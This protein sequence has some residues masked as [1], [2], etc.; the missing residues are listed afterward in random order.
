MKKLLFLL[1]LLPFISHAQPDYKKDIYI[2]DKRCFDYDMGYYYMKKVGNRIFGVTQSF[3]SGDAKLIIMNLNF[4]TIKTVNYGG[5]STIDEL[6]TI[7]ELSNDN[8]LLSGRSASDDGDVNGP[9]NRAAQMWFLEVDTNGIIKKSKTIGGTQGSACLNVTIAKDGF[10]YCIGATNANDYDFQRSLWYGPFASDIVIF[11]LDTAYNIVWNKIFTTAKEEGGGAIVEG[12]NNTFIFSWSCEDTATSVLGSQAKGYWDVFTIQVDSAGNELRKY[13]WGGNQ[14]D[15]NI[16]LYYDSINYRYYYIGFSHS[17]NTDATYRTGQSGIMNLWIRIT[18][19]NFNMLYSKCYGSDKW[20]N[21]GFINL[22]STF[23]QGNLW[24]SLQP[25]V[26]KGDFLTNDNPNDSTDNLVIGIIDTSANLIGKMGIKS[27]VTIQVDKLLEINNELYAVGVTGGTSGTIINNFG[28]GSDTTDWKYFV[29]K[30]GEAPLS[31]KE[32]TK[33]TQANLF[34]FFPNPTSVELNIKWNE[35]YIG[36]NYHLAIYSQEGKKLNS[37]NGVCE[38]SNV[39]MP[40]SNFANG[41]YI[42]KATIN[43][44]IQTQSFIK[45]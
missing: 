34:T 27:N 40:I 31:I 45:Q 32:N 20:F 8:I 17:S 41:K 10:I 21:N 3:P 5:S 13:R 26:Q 44:Q 38:S 37:Y 35:N 23:Y 12:A 6:K 36:K 18:D 24:F 11:K 14:T 16:G 2:K 29:L 9:A 7:N 30:L 43:K 4:D 25:Y 28:C 39:V 33:T 22:K 42:I 15:G 1:L 19:T